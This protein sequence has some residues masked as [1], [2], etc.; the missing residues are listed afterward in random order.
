MQK[1]L[2]AIGTDTGDKILLEPDLD[3][4]FDPTQHVDL[5][6]VDIY[7]EEN[8]FVGAAKVQGLFFGPLAPNWMNID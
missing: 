2:H 1:Q 7:E 3:V 5:N 8:C 4:V 6:A